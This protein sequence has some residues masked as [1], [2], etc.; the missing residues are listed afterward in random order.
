MVSR[1]PLILEIMSKGSHAM[2]VA[3]KILQLL[4]SKLS[5]ESMNIERFFE[6]SLVVAAVARQF[7]VLH[8][9]L[10]FEALHL[11]SAVFCSDYS[12]SFHSFNLC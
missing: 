10:K 8:N 6:L 2:E 4:V 3:I 12:V 5:S 1:I 9:A 11:L 7:A